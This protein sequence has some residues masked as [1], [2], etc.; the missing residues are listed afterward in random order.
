[1]V[2][3]SRSPVDSP[4]SRRGRDNGSASPSP[5]RHSRSRRSR[6][7]ERNGFRQRLGRPHHFGY[8]HDPEHYGKE[9]EESLRQRRVA[10]AGWSGSA[11]FV[12]LKTVVLLVMVGLAVSQMFRPALAFGSSCI[13]L[14]YCC[15]LYYTI[16]YLLFI[17]YF[18]IQFNSLG[19]VKTFF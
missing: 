18:N 5:S 10:A 6:S 14:Y 2:S 7:R 1:M 13:T 8:R 11:G 17:I 15:C 9:Q 19:L 12:G 16:Y 4:G 3:R